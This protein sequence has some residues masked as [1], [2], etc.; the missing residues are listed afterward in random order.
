[1]VERIGFGLGYDSSMTVKEMIVWAKKAEEKGFD[2]IFFSETIQIF[3]DAVSSLASLA[4]AVEKPLLGCT[5]IV[6][7]RSPLVI[8]QTFATL[9]ELSNG[10]IILSLGAATQQHVQKHGLPYADPAETLEEYIITV[11][12]LLTGGKVTFEGKH[13]MLKESGLG[14][15]PV[16]ENLPIWVAATSRKGL[17]IAG[18]YADGVLLNATT[19][20]EYC[21]EAVRIFREAAV[22]AGR[23]PDEL[24]VAGLVVAAVDDG[25]KAVDYVR[26][27][28]AS[29]FSPLMVD[30]AVRP[31]LNVGEPYV[32]RELIEKLLQSY[33]RGGFEQLMKDIPEEVLKGLTASGKPHEVRERIE[34]YKR[35]GVK[36]PIIRP[37]DREI[38]DAV[39][40]SVV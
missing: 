34:E 32:T 17:Q 12:K 5:Q 13:I 26:R 25:K 16:R 38:I 18:R 10:R 33:K 35:A 11:K 4:L 2:V 3:R 27:E 23:N 37:A 30:F 9:D 28:V 6:R 20:V 39:L 22:E 31:R 21:R 19:S 36:L 7:L 8:A 24:T 1:M 15:K 14:F 29:K 40:C